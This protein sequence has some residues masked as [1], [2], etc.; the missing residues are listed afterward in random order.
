[1]TGVYWICNDC[2]PARER[3]V[4]LE[5][6]LRRIA[7]RVGALHDALAEEPWMVRVADKAFQPIYPNM[8]AAKGAIADVLWRD[9]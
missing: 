3:V 2:A 4:E 1:M 9:I 8:M 7:D 5:I 6:L